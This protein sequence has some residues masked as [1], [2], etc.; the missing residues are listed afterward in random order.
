[1]ERLRKIDPADWDPS[2]KAAIKPEDRTPLENG[3]M[4]FYAHRPELDLGLSSFMGALKC[5]AQ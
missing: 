4:R 3:L 1:M 2:L 5:P